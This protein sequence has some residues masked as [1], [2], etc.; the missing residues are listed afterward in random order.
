MDPLQRQ[1]LIDRF[2]LV[3]TDVKNELLNELDD[4]GRQ[5]L[6]SEIEDLKMDVSN[7]EHKVDD[8]ESDKDD[9]E[10]SMKKVRAILEAVNSEDDE[11][12]ESINRCLELLA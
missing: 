6:E 7:L 1:H 10:E 9:L 2:E 11:T 12:I 8:L 5:E 4:D 3:V